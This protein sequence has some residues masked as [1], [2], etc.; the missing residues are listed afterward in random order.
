MLVDSLASCD[1]DRYYVVLAYCT[2]VM[3]SSEVW[4]ALANTASNPYNQRLKQRKTASRSKAAKKRWK[5]VP[6]EERSKQM[7]AAARARWGPPK[8][9]KEKNAAAIALVAERWGKKTPAERRKIMQQ[10]RK[11]RADSTR[12]N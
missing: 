3:L 5:G 2:N 6:P 10:V 7:Q 8:K 4:F 9:T 1:V 12:L 11:G